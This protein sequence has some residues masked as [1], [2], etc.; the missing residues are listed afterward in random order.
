MLPIVTALFQL[1]HPEL[2]AGFRFFF[3]PWSMGSG[4]GLQG[5]S[6]I[7]S[8]HFPINQINIQSL[9]L[10]LYITVAYLVHPRDNPQADKFWLLVWH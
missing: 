6:Q 5:T 2:I 7:S 4:G 10:L 9:S 8:N 3:K 1:D